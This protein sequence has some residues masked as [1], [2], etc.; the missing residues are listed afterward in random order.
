MNEKDKLIIDELKAAREKLAAV[1]RPRGEWRAAM[2]SAFTEE[3]DAEFDPDPEGAPV[4]PESEWKEGAGAVP[5]PTQS[6]R[7]RMRTAFAVETPVLSERTADD[8]A[9]VAEQASLQEGVRASQPRETQNPAPLLRGPWGHRAA[10]A[11]AVAAAVALVVV[12][13]W[14]SSAVNEAPSARSAGWTLVNVSSA[15]S[16]DITPFGAGPADDALEAK[17]ASAEIVDVGESDL[18]LTSSDGLD[19]VLRSGARLE[20]RPFAS[21]C[22]RAPRND[23]LWRSPLTSAR[24]LRRELSRSPRRTS[25][26]YLL[27]SM[28]RRR[29]RPLAAR[30]TT[31]EARTPRPTRWQQSTSS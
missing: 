25:G 5:P 8:G 24:S 19:V 2:R 26:S 14:S 28:D 1:E 23:P 10:G 7:D 12:A 17:L 22:A 21:S 13:R 31:S 16:V 27:W 20:G 29:S 9:S 3:A 11:C 18:T 4:V 6:F 30:R 15:D